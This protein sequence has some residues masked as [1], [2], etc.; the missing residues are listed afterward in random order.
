VIPLILALTLSKP[1]PDYVPQVL[2]NWEGLVEVTI[3]ATDCGE[4][5]A[6]YY[7]DEDTVV[8]C[9]ELFDRPELTRFILNHELAHAFNDQS[10]MPWIDSE[11]AADELAFFMSDQDEVFAGAKWFLGLAKGRKYEDSSK[12]WDQHPHPLDRAGSLLFL[13]EARWE[14]KDASMQCRIYLR[15]TLA[16]WLRWVNADLLQ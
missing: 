13:A 6:Y 12:T 10:G 8:L 9:T 16:H 4:D 7:P 14:P 5:N 11:A 15:S 1:V 2:E 3:L